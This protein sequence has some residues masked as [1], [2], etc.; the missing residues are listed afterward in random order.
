MRAV[1]DVRR[2]IAYLPH[3]ARD[4]FAQLAPDFDLLPQNGADLGAR[5]DHAL[6][7]YLGRGDQRVVDHE[8]RRADAA[9]RVF[10]TSL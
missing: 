2:V 10:A 8:L 1:P 6:T 4:Y 5:L 3:E 9:D 7:Y